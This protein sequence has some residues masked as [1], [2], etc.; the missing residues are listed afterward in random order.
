MP[1]P[2]AMLGSTPAGRVPALFRRIAHQQ[3]ST[4]TGQIRYHLWANSLW[5]LKSA[6]IH[7]R[8]RG[9]KRISQHS[10]ATIQMRERNWVL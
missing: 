2:N 3:H 1:C 10:S 9:Q 4:A 5:A 7:P 8:D 6:L